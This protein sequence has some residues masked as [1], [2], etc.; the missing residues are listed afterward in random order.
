MNRLCRLRTTTLHNHSHTTRLSTTPPRPFPSRPLSQLPWTR[1]CQHYTTTPISFSHRRNPADQNASHRKHMELIFL[2]TGSMVP[3]NARGTSSLLLRLSGELW[4]FDCGEGTQIQMQK[5]ALTLNDITKIFVTHCHGDH[6]FGLPGIL[7]G[8]GQARRNRGPS[9]RKALSSDRVEIYGPVGLRAYLRYVA[10][11][12]HAF[13]APYVVHELEDIPMVSSHTG[14]ETLPHC[15]SSVKCDPTTPSFANGELRGGQQLPRSSEDGCWTLFHRE[16]GMI[17]RAAPLSHTVPTVG[18]VV[19]EPKTLGN[20]NM[21]LLQPILDQHFDDLVKAGWKHPA[22]IISA[23][24]LTKTGETFD[25]PDGTQLH[26]EKYR[27]EDRNGRKIAILGDTSHAGKT[28]SLVEGADVMV[29]ECTNASL[30]GDGTTENGVD[31]ALKSRGHSSP[32]MVGEF[33]KKAKVKRLLL[34]HLSQSIVKRKDFRHIQKRVA[35]VSGLP[36]SNVVVAED[37]M[38]FKDV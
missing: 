14:K 19:E 29:H 33:A 16:D 30:P 1:R 27:G 28:L 2:G 8:M 35:H 34:N 4:M 15:D 31:R 5:T 10:K 7:C 12:S 20:M 13:F 37:L 38:V 3:T 23:I 24:K 22:T 21:Q 11:I 25:M 26:P 9:A 32:R 18:Y 17:V 36:M 6:I